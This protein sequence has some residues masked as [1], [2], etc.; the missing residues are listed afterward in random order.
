MKQ[1]SN[2][3][4]LSQ[5]QLTIHGHVQGVFFRQSSLAIATQLKLAGWVTNNSNKTVSILIMGPNEACQQMI[6]WCH[7]GP[8]KATVTN[9]EIKQETPTYH[10]KPFI[11]Q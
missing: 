2:K 5:Y 6:T 11:I 1:K 7:K 8:S 9:L 10:N 4:T 3:H